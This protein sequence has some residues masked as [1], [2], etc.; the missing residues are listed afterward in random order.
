HKFGSDRITDGTLTAEQEAS[1]IPV[2]ASAIF[3]LPSETN[4][5]FH[6]LGGLGMYRLKYEVDSNIPGFE[7]SGSST[8]FGINVGGGVTFP[9]GQRIDVVAEA[10]FHSLFTEGSNTNMIPLS[11]GLRF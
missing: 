2:V 9:L 6:L 10:R 8:D 11:F 4:T 5:R 1:M 3:V 7:G